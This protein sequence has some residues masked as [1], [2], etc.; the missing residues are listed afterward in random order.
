MG[1]HRQKKSRESNWQFDSR[2]LKVGN[3]PDF[4]LCK[5]RATYRWKALD[6]GN[7]FAFEPHCDQ[8]STCE[9]MHSQNRE[10]PNWGNFHIQ[11][12]KNHLDV[13]HVER[14][15]LYYKRGRWWLPPQV[16]AVVSLVCPSYLW[17]V[18]A[19]KMLQ[20]CTGHFVLVLC[21]FV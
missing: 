15:K 12:T 10:S 14:R 4:L 21:R 19:P 3:R 11:M 1:S 9:V 8:R 17:F 16:R 6:E 20:L 18:L 13:A 5:R 7:N 2:P